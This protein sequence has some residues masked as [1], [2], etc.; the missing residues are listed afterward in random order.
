M[1]LFDYDNLIIKNPKFYYDLETN[2]TGNN[3]LIMTKILS[4]YD[5]IILKDPRFLFVSRIKF[6][7]LYSDYFFFKKSYKELNKMERFYLTYYIFNID[8]IKSY[9]E[10][11]SES[12]YKIMKKTTIQEMIELQKSLEKLHQSLNIKYKGLINQYKNTKNYMLKKDKEKFNFL[13]IT[14]TDVPM[15]THGFYNH[16]KINKIINF[17]REE[18]NKMTKTLNIDSLSYLV[19]EEDK[20]SF[21]K[22]LVKNTPQ[23]QLFLLNELENSFK[24]TNNELHDK[25]QNSMLSLQQQFDK[26]S[27]N[28][29]LIDNFL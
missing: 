6:A 19:S 8:F 7:T 9:N 15:D 5:Y 27:T 4:Y 22:F 11:Q 13:E 14:S 24:M 28:D 3:L 10:F 26:L 16:R 21:Q 18:H 20:N 2:K 12:N 1:V 29:G 25:L 17:L 23:S